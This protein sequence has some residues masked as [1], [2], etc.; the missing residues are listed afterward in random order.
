MAFATRTPR[1]RD[2]ECDKRCRRRVDATP[3]RRP[4]KTHARWELLYLRLFLHQSTERFQIMVIIMQVKLVVH[5][6][7]AQDCRCVFCLL[8]SGAHRGARAQRQQP[9]S[10]SIPR[11]VCIRVKQVAASRCAHEHRAAQYRLSG[12]LRSSTTPAVRHADVFYRY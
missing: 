8:D 5:T 1:G 11:W 2:R 7:S 9:A 10:R 12:C 3:Q 4:W 6:S